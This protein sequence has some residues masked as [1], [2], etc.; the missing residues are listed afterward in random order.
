MVTSA[1]LRTCANWTRTGNPCV[2][3]TD[4]APWSLR[5]CADLTGAPTPTSASCVWRRA[6]NG[7]RSAFSS[8]ESAAQ[9]ETI[10][11]NEICTSIPNESNFHLFERS[12]YEE[13]FF[14]EFN[15]FS[16]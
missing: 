10:I 8:E 3:V 6:R 13:S 16:L 7:R 14:I 15:S 4:Y 12:I 2:G 11:H 1:L 9:V 5:L